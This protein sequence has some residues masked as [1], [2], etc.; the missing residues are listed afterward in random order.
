M[1]ELSPDDLARLAAYYRAMAM[2][3]I[4]E[5]N[6]NALELTPAAH[7]IIVARFLREQMKGEGR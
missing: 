4:L 7:A 2:E 6:G 5:A 1:T 3:L